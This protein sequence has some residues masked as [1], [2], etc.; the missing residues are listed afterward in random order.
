MNKSDG[1]D[2]NQRVVILR[3]KE[4]EHIKKELID[5]QIKIGEYKAQLK[6]YDELIP[7]IKDVLKKQGAL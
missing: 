4:Y 6:V 7:I 1:F 5:C 2:K 3:E